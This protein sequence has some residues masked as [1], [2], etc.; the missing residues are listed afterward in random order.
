[1]KILGTDSVPY[2]NPPLLNPFWLLIPDPVVSGSNFPAVQL[3]GFVIEKLNLMS[4]K[5]LTLS[6]NEY[7]APIF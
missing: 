3:N 4:S 6:P 1:M 2:A 5:N 7:D